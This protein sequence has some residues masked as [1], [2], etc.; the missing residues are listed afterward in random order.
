MVHFKINV[1]HFLSQNGS[2]AEETPMRTYSEYP[3]SYTSA[4]PV[5]RFEDFQEPVHF[6]VP[7]G[8]VID[9][10]AFNYIDTMGVHMLKQVS[11]DIFNN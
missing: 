5:E 8:I 3:L 2:I 10:S 4:M 11:L 6:D 9:A 7:D 1:V